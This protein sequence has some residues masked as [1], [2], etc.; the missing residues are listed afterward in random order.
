MD[1]PVLKP[2]PIPTKGVGIFTRIW[3]WFTWVRKWEVVEDFIFQFKDLIFLIP[4]GFIFDGASIPRIFWAFLSPT[5]LLLI[6]GLI[7]DYAYRHD[8]LWVL[9]PGQTKYREGAGKDF[10][11]KLFMEIG[12]AV[13][14][15]HFANWV[16]WVA[17]KVGGWTAW[18]HGDAKGR[19]PP[20]R[21]KGIT[22][23]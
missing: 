10:W 20:Q 2:I 19:P 9:C 5:G 7:H 12:E 17:L 4:K 21:G 14:G 13:N 1:M 23:Y 15:V 16:A 6:P 8:F 3:R 18:R 11:D 22:D